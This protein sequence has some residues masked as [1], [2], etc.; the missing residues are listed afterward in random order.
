MSGNNAPDE[1]LKIKTKHKSINNP[2]MK[3]TTSISDFSFIPSGYGHYLVTY[4]SVLGKS[5][6]TIVSDMSLIDATK[7]AEA[8]TRKALNALKKACKAS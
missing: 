7:N 1:S 2:I 6:R 5:W 3:T 8:P 4:T